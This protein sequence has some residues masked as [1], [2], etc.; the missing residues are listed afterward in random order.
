[1]EAVDGFV[2]FV[3]L[4]IQ[5]QFLIFFVLY[6][7]GIFVMYAIIKIKIIKII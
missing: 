3:G 7:D 6:V 4:L 1:M 2:I 5:L